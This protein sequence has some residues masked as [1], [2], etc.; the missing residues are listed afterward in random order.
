MRC[1]QLEPTLFAGMVLYAPML[2][3][4][5]AREMEIGCGFKNSALVRVCFVLCAVCYVSCGV[6]VLCARV[7]WRAW[8]RVEGTYRTRKPVHTHTHTLTH[9]HT[10]A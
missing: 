7:V 1:A 3:L 5:L 10:H 2:S 9:A 8:V 6:C 4:E